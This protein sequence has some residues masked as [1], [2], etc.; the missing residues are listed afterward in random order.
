VCAWAVTTRSEEQL[1]SAL[2]DTDYPE[3]VLGVSKRKLKSLRFR[4]RRRSLKI[5]QMG[6]PF[7]KRESFKNV[8]RQSAAFARKRDDN[9]KF[10]NVPIRPKT[11][12]S[13]PKQCQI[14]V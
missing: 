1:L 6:C 9:G 10:L 13:K 12:A 3:R 8:N 4:L 5:A 2:H 7:N 11:K 14:F